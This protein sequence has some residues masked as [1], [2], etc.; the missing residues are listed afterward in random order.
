MADRDRDIERSHNRGGVLGILIRFIVTAVVLAITS[1]LTPGF[2]I[3]GLWSIIIA[4]VVISLLDYL[5]ERLMR[6]DASP[7]GR[8][9][10]GFAIAAIILYIAQFLVPGMSVSIIGAILA[11]VVIGVVD[12]LIP[13]RAM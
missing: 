2:T 8:G 10:K 11:A 7:F 5:A 13:G 3:I 12:A 6:V 1:Y 4:A 9:F